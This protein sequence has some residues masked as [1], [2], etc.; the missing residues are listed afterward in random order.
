MT[1]NKWAGSFAMPFRSTL[2][3]S[4]RSET[5][6]TTIDSCHPEAW[7]QEGPELVIV[8]AAFPAVFDQQRGTQAVNLSVAHGKCPP[9]LK[10]EFFDLLLAVGSKS[11]AHPT[12][13]SETENRTEGLMLHFGP[14]WL[15]WAHS[16]CAYSQAVWSD[17][18]QTRHAANERCV[19]LS[20]AE[21]IGRS[22]FL[23]RYFRS[24]H[25]ICC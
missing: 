7:C 24:R 13:P 22:S 10:K 4:L 18:C 8:R 12:P 2:A 6:R 25:G 9:Y 1:A 17:E 21:R 23:P 20:R 14:K 5:L 16:V 3:S 11:S 19:L 15:R